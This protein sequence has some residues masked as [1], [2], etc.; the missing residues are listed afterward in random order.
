MPHSKNKM[1][2]YVVIPQYLVNQELRELSN[3]T[4]KSM[5][6]SSDVIIIS[7]NDGAKKYE[8]QRMSDVYLENKENSGFAKTCN[9]G[10]EWIFKNVKEDCYIVCANN[11]IEV[12]DGWLEALQRPFTEFEDVAVTG[13]KHTRERAIEGKPLA[14][15]KG[16]KVI[17][18][19]LMGDCMQDG[20][21]WMSTKKVLKK[22]GIFDE[23]FERG[24]YEDVDIFLRMRDTFG[25]KIIMTEWACY[26]HKEGATRWGIEDGG[27]N[28]ESQGYEDRNRIK[29]KNKWGF[30]YRASQVWKSNEIIS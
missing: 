10:F 20:G 23:Q 4:I 24:G 8:S 1:K 22:V 28:K 18:G 14:E 2:T 19:G 29:F 13:I 6:K 5:R 21:L 11:D 12:Y 16:T 3:N 26:W 17:E 25:M 27:F 30:D 15:V 7:V 9:K